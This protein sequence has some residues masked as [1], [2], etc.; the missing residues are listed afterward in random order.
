MP[1]RPLPSVAN[2]ASATISAETA[3]IFGLPARRRQPVSIGSVF[4]G[5]YMVEE[6]IGSG[7]FGTV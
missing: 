6:H 1:K 5:R 3:G 7:G 2:G 4:A